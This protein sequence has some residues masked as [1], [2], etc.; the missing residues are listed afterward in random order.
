MCGPYMS[1]WRR[2]AFR[3]FIPVLRSVLLS[4]CSHKSSVIFIYIASLCIA[5]SR[6]L[7]KTE[8]PVIFYRLARLLVGFAGMIA[9]LIGPI[10]GAIDYWWVLSVQLLI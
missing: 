2:P 7:V 5:P 8:T 9:G 4:S 1:Y 10:A 6:T 3:N